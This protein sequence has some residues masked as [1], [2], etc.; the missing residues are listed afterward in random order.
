MSSDFKVTLLG[1]GS[2]VPSLERFG[3]ATLVEAGELK[4]LFDCGRGTMQRL[5][6]IN[7]N[8]SEFNKLFLTHLHSDH[9]TGIPDLWITGRLL[10][11]TESPLRIWG[12]KGTRD[13][14]RHLQEAF[15]ID[16]KVRS[17][18]RVVHDGVEW[19]VDGLKIEVNEFDE[20]YI[21]EENNVRVIP[22][23]V[24]HHKGSDVPS[25]GFR[26][27]YEGY[28]V[29]ISGDT[30]YSEN[31]VKY[32]EGVDLLIHEVAAAPL[33]EEIPEGIEFIL[34]YHTVPEEC[35]QIFT[36][37]RPK[38]AVYNHILLFMGVT[39]EEVM[40]RTKSVYD[41]SIIVGEDMMQI[42]IGETVQVNNR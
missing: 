29:V 40:E 27:E 38:L 8:A 3:P 41:G 13:M 11:R 30:S 26:V 16:T 33:D 23:K 6:Q 9:T 22:F 42:Q 10:N 36:R 35:G 1:T 31:L 37:V 21:Y 19:Q 4:L 15:K 20:G 32:S 14:I 12:Q 18:A 5:F 7:R 34:S 17:V 24:P 39:L 25:Y 28:S 2:P